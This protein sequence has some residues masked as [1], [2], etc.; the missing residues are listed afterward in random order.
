MN[1]I[2]AAEI[3]NVRHDADHLVIKAA[4]HAL[5]KKH[6][7]D[8]G[9]DTAMMQRI[10]AA[11]DYMSTRTQVARNTEWERLQKPV[12]YSGRLDDLHGEMHAA[13]RKAEAAKAARPQYTTTRTWIPPKPSRIEQYQNWKRR[14]TRPVRWAMALIHALFILAGRLATAA[15]VFYAYGESVLWAVKSLAHG[16]YV[17]LIIFPGI[18]VVIAG[19]ILAVILAGLFLLDGWAGWGDFFDGTR[20]NTRK[21]WYQQ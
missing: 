6:H 17:L 18:A 20:L 21:T 1:I 7:P 2:E 19:L 10:N 13:N 3:M 11:H 15:G 14:Q 5:G 16:W 12:G 9:G 4:F 8:H